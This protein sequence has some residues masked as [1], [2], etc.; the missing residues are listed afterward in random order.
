MSFLL[1]FSRLKKKKKL[2]LIGERNLK[3]HD[4]VRLYVNYYEVKL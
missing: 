2:F 1:L 3:V 4:D